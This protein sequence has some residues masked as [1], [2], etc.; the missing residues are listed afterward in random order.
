MELLVLEKTPRL[1]ITLTVS[2]STTKTMVMMNP[3]R[4]KSRNVSGKLFLLLLKPWKATP[5]SMMLPWI[6]WPSP[7]QLVT[8]T[9]LEVQ[10]VLEPLLVPLLELWLLCYCSCSWPSATRTAMKFRI[11]SLLKT[12]KPLSMS[13]K[14]SL[15]TLIPTRKID[16]STLWE[17]PIPSCL[18]G[19]DTR[20]TKIPF[21]VM[22]IDR[23]NWDTKWGMSTFVRLP[24][25]RRANE[26]DKWVS[27][28]SRR[29]RRPCPSERRRFH[30]MPRENMWQK[31]WWHCKKELQN[32]HASFLYNGK[33]GGSHHFCHHACILCECECLC[34][35]YRTPSNRLPLATTT[36]CNQ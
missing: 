10:L 19:L 13:L 29:R 34:A 35:L 36:L 15:E 16:A 18:A 5:T 12:M 22:P 6:L 4:L 3:M 32:N 2:G 7:R 1:V 33:K 23:A 8:I 21:A 24:L 11:S 17:N 27:R 25:V 31:M 9:V 14:E 28:S 30:E 26:D 20:W